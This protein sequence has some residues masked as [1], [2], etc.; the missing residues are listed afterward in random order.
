MKAWPPPESFGNVDSKT[1]KMIKQLG[2]KVYDF[3]PETKINGKI[4]KPLFLKN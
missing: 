2:R 1:L 4:I 3:Y